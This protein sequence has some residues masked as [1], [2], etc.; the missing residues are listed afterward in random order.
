[1]PEIYP[2]R[3]VRACEWPDL[4][5][6][7]RAG[8]PWLDGLPRCI[9]LDD[10]GDTFTEK[11]DNPEYLAGVVAKALQDGKPER[12]LYRDALAAVEGGGH[13]LDPFLARM[14]EAPHIWMMLTKL[15]NSLRSLIRNNGQMIVPLPL[16][17]QRRRKLRLK[18][19]HGRKV[20]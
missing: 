14:A 1:M 13:W 2:A 20:S 19:T 4:T 18:L 3:I 10:M 7:K 16:E 6:T 15:Q 9:F 8:K 12:Q 11:L 17:G 5:G